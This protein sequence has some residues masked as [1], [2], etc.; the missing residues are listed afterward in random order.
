MKTV[1]INI[2]I[3]NNAGRGILCGILKY[4]STR[5]QWLIRLL[6]HPNG[7]SKASIRQ[8]QANGVDGIITN[9]VTTEAI[10]KELNLTQI[11]I[12][13]VDVHHPA[14]RKRQTKTAFVDNKN[15]T[16]GAI[17]AK[18]FLSLGRF[19]SY[20]FIGHPE[21]PTWAEERK[22]GY[23]TE[24]KKHHI[25]PTVLIDDISTKL[26]KLPRPVAIMAAWDYK[27]I[28]VL[29]SCRK[30]NLRVPADVSVIGVDAD[31]LLCGFTNP[32]LT[33]VAPDFERLGY[34]AAAALDAMMSGRKIKS[35]N[36]ILCRPK[37]VVERA[38]TKFLPP[39]ASLVHH[40]KEIIERDAVHGLTVH[41]LTA[42]LGI[43]QQLLSLRFRQV[44]KK[45]VQ[46]TILSTKL[47]H[48]QALLGEDYS[49]LSSVAHA[50]GFNSANRLAHLFKQRYGMSLG[51][52]ARKARA[53][54][55]K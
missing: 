47:L 30:Q 39:A 34:C 37:G 20:V 13:F 42:R 26:T 35:A 22:I 48:A 10:A 52:F 19:R 14:I 43:S 12:S 51:A 28:E 21:R 54:S 25:T 2:E 36:V 45:S 46:E 50:C 53:A 41:D 3:N 11:P 23:C 55:P 1:M 32:S 24:L 16:I 44:E 6:S 31:P 27:A 15:A 4:T 38:S 5:G 29:E 9:N 7:M 49:S 40:A 18:K 17:G 8:A 33:S